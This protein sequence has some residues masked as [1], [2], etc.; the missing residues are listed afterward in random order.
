MPDIADLLKE[1]LAKGAS[2][3]HITTESA[4]M[5]RVDGVL[6]P[7]PY[8]Q[9]DPAT[10]KALMYSVMTEEQKRIFEENLELDFS[11]GLSGMARFRANCFEQRGGVAGAL[12]VVPWQIPSFEELGIPKV[13]KEVSD[14]PRG[15]VLVTGPTGSGKSTSLAA[16]IDHI[17][18]TRYEHI[19]TI[20]DP[21]EFLHPHKN[22]IVNQRELHANTLSFPAAMRA[23]LRE[24]PD[25]VLIGEMRDR[26]STELALSL[27]ETG[28][29]T[30]A[31]LHTNSAV[32][33]INRIIDIFPADQQQ[34]IRTQL[35]FVLEAVMSQSLL[36]AA[37][38][39][40]RV[41]AAEVMIPNSA[42]RNLMREDKVHQIPSLMQSGQAEHGMQTFNQALARL[43]LRGRI[44]RETAIEASS[45]AKELIP[46]IERAE[47][48]GGGRAQR[49]G[50]PV[51]R[52]R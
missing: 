47:A 17:N 38:G 1:M 18:Q 32:S 40:G 50:R 52:M 22:C 14:R 48:S 16:M 30:F 12:R 29:L 46:M 5:I 19:I 13:M 27:A 7:L 44:T 25:I 26:E 37:R 10:T 11:F 34:Q 35:S 28:H 39:G 42:I 24:D 49:R 2:D 21:I 43:V 8:R 23:A 33:S 20:E 36:A 9:L 6:K 3:L 4:P 31:T 41:L 45:D 51:G 15:L